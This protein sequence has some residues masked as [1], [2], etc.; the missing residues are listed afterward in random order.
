MAPMF[1][2]DSIHPFNCFLL[3]GNGGVIVSSTS[4]PFDLVKRTHDHRTEWKV[5]T[6]RFA[7]KLK[8]GY[9]NLITSALTATAEKTRFYFTPL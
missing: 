4:A 9:S 2:L 1:A 7:L 6:A 3:C 5:R 8:V